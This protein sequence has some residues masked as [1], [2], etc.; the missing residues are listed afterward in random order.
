M[1]NT[2]SCCGAVVD[3]WNSYVQLQKTIFFY[4]LEDVQMMA[5]LC[6]Q[7]VFACKAPELCPSS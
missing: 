7:I 4:G 3:L 5:V 6:E 2:E 1:D